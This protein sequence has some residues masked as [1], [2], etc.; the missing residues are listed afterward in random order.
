MIQSASRGKQFDFV[1]SKKTVKVRRVRLDLIS[2]ITNWLETEDS[3]L[4][5]LFS[6]VILAGTGMFIIFSVLN[7]IF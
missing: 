5:K 6:A 1:F 3:E 4:A 2:Q 7:T